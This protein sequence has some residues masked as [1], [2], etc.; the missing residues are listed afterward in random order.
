MT[1]ETGDLEAGAVL[2]GRFEIAREIG[3]GG[4]SVVYAARDRSV[5]TEV[6]IKVLVPPPATAREAKE[7]LRREVQAI[8]GLRH[9]NIVGVHDLVEDG[10]IAF[11]VMDLI[12][13]TDLASR[14][15][16][17]GPLPT[18]LAIGV[19]VQVSDAL[20]EAHRAGILHRDI[21][22]A[23]ILL[24]GAGHAWLT[25]FGSARLDSQTTITRTGGLVGTVAYL[26]PEVW[27]GGRADARADLY[28]LGMTLYEALTGK[29]PQRPS[30]HLPPTPEGDGFKPSLHRPDLPPWLE[31]VIARATTA[32]PRDR[33][34][35]VAAFRDALVAR[36]AP[37]A[38]RALLLEATSPP[39]VPA[40]P[41][42]PANYRL[43]VAGVAGTGALAGMA[44]SPHFFWATPLVAG[45]LIRGGRKAMT[46]SASPLPTAITH[47][48][49]HWRLT[50]ELERIANALPA[51]GARTI[52]DDVLTLAQA[53][54]SD[55]TTPAVATRRRDQL[56][57]I[58][59]S[60]VRAA[61][62]LA[63]VDNDLNRLERAAS[64]VRDIP[65]RWWD[66]LASLERARDAIS[67]VLLE[68]VGTLGR[69][70]GT[71]AVDFNSAQKR[72]DDLVGEFAGDVAAYQGAVS[73]LGTGS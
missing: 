38:P 37:P 69:A 40:K 31:R 53:H 68:L 54:L 48:P 66:G 67:T 11:V 17:R 16:E 30:V 52:L 26:A 64:G 57:P 44:A 23:N 39:P 51:G 46:A 29:L 20:A 73:D 56:E 61:Q 28:S 7:R 35:T 5:G 4:Y 72:L 24:D 45:L 12:D 6:A 70:R 9:P 49:E 47:G 50:G 65:E 59:T 27:L 41:R 71:D 3:R 58:V 43:L 21:K 36:R 18:E 22:P 42:L 8:R 33:F 25:D 55:A 1:R 32:E 10:S 34:A 60:A 63:Q 13:G 62:R 2:G 15:A 14:I 19:A